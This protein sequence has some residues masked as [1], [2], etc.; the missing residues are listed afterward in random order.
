MITVRG[1][2]VL[3]TTSALSAAA[4]PALHAQTAPSIEQ[5][6]FF[7]SPAERQRLD[8]MRQTAHQ[9]EKKQPTKVVQKKPPPPPLPPVQVQG[10][11]VRSNGPDVVWVNDGNTLRDDRISGGIRVQTGETGTVRI[12]IPNR[13]SVA[14]RPGQS[15]D[16]ASG[17]T[18][19]IQV[20]KR[21]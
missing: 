7:T 3:L 17:K 1:L 8:A 2:M 4:A 10:I 11:V 16:P 9:P 13:G 12:E 18:T 14:L 5:L 20:R 6:R 21:P 19:G 15:Y